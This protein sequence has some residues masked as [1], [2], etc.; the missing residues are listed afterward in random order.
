M[1]DQYSVYSRKHDEY[2]PKD[3]LPSSKGVLYSVSQHVP[4]VNTNF[5]SLCEGVFA[6]FGSDWESERARIMSGTNA[7]DEGNADERGNDV[8]NAESNSIPAAAALVHVAVGDAHTNASVIPTCVYLMSR[9]ALHMD[10]EDTASATTDVICQAIVNCDELGLN[11]QLAPQIFTLWMCSPLLELQLKPTHKPYDIKQCWRSL[12]EQYSHGTLNQ[13]QRDE[14][15]IS[16]QRNIFF[17]QTVEEKIKDQKIIELLYEEA[18]Y[19]ILEGRYPCETAHYIMLGGIQARL[20]LGPYN[21]QVH[22]THYF[23]EEQAKYLP[24]HVRKS[25][26]WTWLPISSKNSAEVRLLEQ[27]KRI[28]TSATNR[29]LMRKYIEFCWSLPYYGAAF[30][31]GQIEQPVRGLTS[32]MTH[33]DI[34]VLVAVNARGVYVIDEIQCTLLLGLQYEEL[35]WDHAKPSKE[36]D[37]NCLPC[38]FLQFVV[39]ENGARVSKILQVFSKQATLMDKV[40]A[41]YVHQMKKKSTTDETDRSNEHHSV[42]NGDVHMPITVGP[43]GHSTTPV[44]CLSNKLSRLTLATFDEDGRCIGQMGSWSFGY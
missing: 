6:S 30:F 23:R 21:P 3:E 18:K 32:L 38:I 42:G 12:L 33:Q 40:I 25:S 24:V 20:E 43:Q 39:L 28:P 16:F 4:S 13:K 9:V 17:S 1:V 26:T 35:S 34:P 36:D 10:I 29:K 8:Q 22:S 11:R 19:N 14:P 37:P 15:V 41:G 5:G 31:E 7:V 2:I 27:F 44:T